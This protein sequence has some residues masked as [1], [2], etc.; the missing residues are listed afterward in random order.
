MSARHLALGLCCICA[1]LLCGAEATFAAGPRIAKITPTAAVAGAVVDVTGRG[2]PG[3]SAGVTVGGKP[4]RVLS[5]TSRRLRIVVPAAKP[6]RQVVRVRGRQGTARGRLQVLRPFK[7]TIGVRPDTKRAARST[8]GPDGGSVTARAADGTSF[9]L[10]VPAG[11]LAAPTQLTMTPVTRLT[12]VP[13][14][15]GFAAAAHFAPEGLRFAQP[16]TLTVTLPKG[17]AGGRFVGFGYEG[18]GAAV[19]FER[20]R[21]SGRTVTVQVEHFSGAGAGLATPADFANALQPFVNAPGALAPAQVTQMLQLIAAFQAAFG[22]GICK[23]QPVCAAAEQKGIDS[24]T[25]H[26]AQNCPPALATPSLH[27][28][29]EVVG[30]FAQLQT[31]GGTQENPDRCEH[32]IME[33]IVTAARAAA[34]GDPLADAGVAATEFRTPEARARNDVDGDGRISNWEWLFHLAAE[35]SLLG[36]ADLSTP[37][38]DDVENALIMLLG[39]ALAECDTNVAEGTR[40]L[41][42]GEPYARRAVILHQDF[43]DALVACPIR[44]GVSPT[45]TE[46]FTGAQQQFSATVTGNPD[47]GVV[48]SASGGSISETGLFTAP[49]T[50]GT[51]EV[52]A[53][54]RAAPQRKAVAKVTAIAVNVTV[55]PANTTMFTGGKRQFTAQVTGHPNTAVNWSSPTGGSVD[56]SGLYTAPETPGTYH[57]TAQSQANPASTGTAGVTVIENPLAGRWKGVYQEYDFG[58]CGNPCNDK[59]GELE[60]ETNG[61]TFTLYFFRRGI[62]GDDKAVCGQGTSKQCILVTGTVSGSSLTGTGVRDPNQARHRD[63]PFSATKAGA[64]LTGRLDIDN[65]CDPGGCYYEF[66]FEKQP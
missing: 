62:F 32:D 50:G 64:E 31:I 7:G 23:T 40:M 54:S 27:A 4:A 15:G 45:S 35:A 13:L 51:Y 26:I 56:A 29:R 61:S 53:T 14:T 5:G 58:D 16:A 36:F 65:D 38:I 57:V 48:W 6:G 46:M 17:V 12:G 60:I 25:H 37:A 43:L 11:A 21:R 1:A 2:L 3:R 47:T 52:T 18:T 24:L 19:F 34:V 55:S 66:R 8:I 22:G 33:P 9:V 28:L 10:A 49:S 41:N 30:L 20:A 44:I 42:G 63:L 59:P 39:R